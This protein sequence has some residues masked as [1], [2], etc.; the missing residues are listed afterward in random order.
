MK[1]QRIQK[2]GYL[3]VNRVTNL[4]E[5]GVGATFNKDGMKTE[6]QKRQRATPLFRK[7]Q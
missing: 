6:D 5:K 7:G 4:D 2:P 1:I 3:K